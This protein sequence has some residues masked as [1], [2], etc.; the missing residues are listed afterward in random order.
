MIQLTKI[1]RADESVVSVVAGPV[2]LDD[3]ADE[4]AGGPDESVVS[5]VAGPVDPDDS[6]DEDAGGPDEL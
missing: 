1:W 5:V 3:S 4:D 6:A 2:D